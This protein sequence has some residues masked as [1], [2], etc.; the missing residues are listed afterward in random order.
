MTET[1]RL[2][3]ANLNKF[4]LNAATETS[5]KAQAIKAKLIIFTLQRLN[6]KL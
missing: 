3:A 2:F 6:I 5:L 4:Q 1:N